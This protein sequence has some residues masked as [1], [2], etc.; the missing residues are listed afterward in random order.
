V[1]ATP[2][3]EWIALVAGVCIGASI[4]RATTRASPPV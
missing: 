4:G 2:W 3:W 1:H